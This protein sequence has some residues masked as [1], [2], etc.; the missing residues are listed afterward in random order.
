MANEKVLVIEDDVALNNVMC[1]YLNNEGFEVIHEF[2]GK[3]G[4]ASAIEREPALIVLDIMLPQMDGIEV[5]R[6]IRI[7]SHAPIIIISAKSSDYDKIVSL[8]VGADDY[9]TKPFSMVELVARVKS[10]VR[11]YTTFH[12]S[13]LGVE[14]SLSK[15]RTYGPL[16]IDPV[17]YTATVNGVEI[18]FAVKEFKLLDYLSQHPSMV[19]TKDQLIDNVWGY[20][21][22]LDDN[23]IAVYIGRLREKLAKEGINPIRTVWGVGYKWEM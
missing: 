19:F 20:N 11:R 3:A 17:S 14:P 13:Q 23:T 21:E 7:H 22:Y 12:S 9:L 5:C 1:D 4:L 2:S 16:T 10:H 18:K 6:N 8:G 15:K